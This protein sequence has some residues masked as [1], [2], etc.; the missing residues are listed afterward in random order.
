[1]KR[2][3]FALFRWVPFVRDWETDLL[4]DAKLQQLKEAEG[5]R[6]AFEDPLPGIR[7]KQ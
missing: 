2:L 5:R 4:I 6:L 3:F 1:M 7:F